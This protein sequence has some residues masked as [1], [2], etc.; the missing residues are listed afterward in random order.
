MRGIKRHRKNR[1][2][3]R[4]PKTKLPPGAIAAL[5]KQY[6]ES[7]L[8]EK[9][10]ATYQM[11]CRYED[12]VSPRL[13]LMKKAIEEMGKIQAKKMWKDIVLARNPFKEL[14][15]KRDFCGAYIPVPFKYGGD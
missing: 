7:Y 1:F 15:K 6:Y 12:R 5:L 9:D 8:S 14:V 3:P 4:E 13:L 11:I 2:F 10:D